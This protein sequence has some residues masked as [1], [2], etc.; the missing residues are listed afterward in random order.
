[1]STPFH[2]AQGF[3]LI[4]ANG[5]LAP[6]AALTGLTEACI[7][8]YQNENVRGSMPAHV[9][10]VL[11]REI[12]SPLYSSALVNLVTPVPSKGLLEDS[13]GAAKVAGALPKQIHDA[14]A[15]GRIDELERRVLSAAADELRA[16]ADAI[17]ASLSDPAM[18]RAS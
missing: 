13:M 5:G 11:E 16:T 7:S 4:K 18:Q 3:R 17:Q 15:D 1:M 9:M 2:K 12:N 10:E 6:C 8:G 14:L